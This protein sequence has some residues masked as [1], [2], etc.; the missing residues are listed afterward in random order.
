MVKRFLSKC[1]FAENKRSHS[2]AKILEWRI[3]TLHYSEAAGK[4]GKGS[5]TIFT[6]ADLS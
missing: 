5:H 6:P 2:A 4:A 1:K 3:L